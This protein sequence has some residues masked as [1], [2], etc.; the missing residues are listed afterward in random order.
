ML[1]H[2]MLCYV[3]LSPC[4][5]L[6]LACH[7][8]PCSALSSS[9]TSSS[10]CQRWDVYVDPLYS[11]Y[12]TFLSYFLNTNDAYSCSWVAYWGLEREITYDDDDDVVHIHTRNNH[13]SPTYSNQASKTLLTDMKDVFPEQTLWHVISRSN[14]CI[15]TSPRTHCYNPCS[16][17]PLF[18][19]CGRGLSVSVRFDINFAIAFSLGFGLPQSTSSRFSSIALLNFMVHLHGLD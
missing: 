19:S 5:A 6:L 4:P 1:C 2:A 11:R 17:S 3:M 12:V 16:H 8:M 13:N 9:S 15:D 14:V 18:A 10:C 7:A